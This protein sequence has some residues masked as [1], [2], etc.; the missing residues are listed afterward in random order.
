M[1]SKNLLILLAVFGILIVI[2]LIQNL[3]SSKKTISESQIELYPDLNSSSVTTIKAYKQLYPDSGLVFTKKD[4]KWLVSSYY[5]APA[6]ESEIEKIFTDLKNLQGEVRSIS[7]DLFGDYDITDDM[8]LHLELL[9]PDSEVVAHVLFGKGVPQASR[10]SFI[11]NIDSDTVYMASENFVSRFAVWNAEP[12]KKFATKRWLELTMANFDK[13][14]AS[15]LALKDNKK[16]YLFAK[17][18]EMA[19]EDTIETTK[20][21]WAQIEPTKDKLDDSKISDIVGRIASLRATDLLGTEILPEYKLTDPK[22]TAT[23]SLDDGTQ[24]TV[25]FGAETDTTGSSRYVMVEGKPYVYKIAKYNYESI[26]VNPFK[27]D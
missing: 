19:M 27:K 12:A 18:E 13:T 3:G 2:Y 20:T 26:F 25:A 22:Q 4:G 16:T 21:V 6:K 8:A 9:G 11:R 10:S 15:T 5:D 23:V 1:R 14:T 7:Q 24:F 17:H